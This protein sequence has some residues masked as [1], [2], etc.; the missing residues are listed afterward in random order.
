MMWSLFFPLKG[1][2]FSPLMHLRLVFSGLF[3]FLKSMNIEF[4]SKEKGRLFSHFKPLR[5]SYLLKFTP[6]EAVNIAYRSS[7]K[8]QKHPLDQSFEVPSGGSWRLSVF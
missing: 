6:Y 1:H 5:I 3:Y 7:I 4:L 8:M 2:N